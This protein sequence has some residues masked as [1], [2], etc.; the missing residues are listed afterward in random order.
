MSAAAFYQVFTKSSI[1]PSV[2]NSITGTDAALGQPLVTNPV[3]TKDSKRKLENCASQFT[4]ISP[5]LGGHR[6]QKLTQRRVILHFGQLHLSS[7]HRSRS[8]H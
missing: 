3:N 5:E 7:S 4:R 2:I 1:L 8:T 6:L